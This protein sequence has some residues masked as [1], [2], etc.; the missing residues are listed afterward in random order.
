MKILF[1]HESIAIL[2]NHIEGLLEFLNLG[3]IEHGKHVAGGTLGA[4][5]SS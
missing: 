5:L 3:L 1:I 4:F 2:V